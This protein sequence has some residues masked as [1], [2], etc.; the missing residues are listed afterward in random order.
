[1]IDHVR[2][3]DGMR[4]SSMRG[5]GNP[6]NA[7]VTES[8]IDELAAAHKTDPLEFR[9]RLLVGVPRA[10]ALLDVVAAMS[11]WSAARPADR[12]LGLC[13]RNEDGTLVGMVAEVSVERKTGGI[14]VHNVWAAI[15]AGL[16]LQPDNIAAQIEGAIVYTLGA[17]LSERVSM[18][19]GAVEQSNF[20]DYQVPRLSDVPEIAVRVLSTPNPPS[21]IGEMG[22]NVSGAVANA[23]A[24]ATGARVRHMP[25]TAER[26]LAALRG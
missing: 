11:N 4:L 13:F 17:V 22:G 3:T 7:F 9:R 20:Y 2:Q 23:V 19:Q 8:F 5:T 25:L 1:L 26:V 12:G 24:A 15:D 10:S 21:G 18:K 6:P 16:A 14:K